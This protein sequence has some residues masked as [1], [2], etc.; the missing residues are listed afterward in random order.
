MNCKPTM[1]TS[2]KNFNDARKMIEFFNFWEM[3][4]NKKKFFRCLIIRMDGNAS[5]HCAKAKLMFNHPN[6]RDGFVL[7]QWF[8]SSKQLRIVVCIIAI[9]FFLIQALMAS[10]LITANAV[11]LL[12]TLTDSD[13]SATLMSKYLHT[14]FFLFVPSHSSSEVNRQP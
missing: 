9:R 1:T 13:A 6:R 12:C 7:K 14:H 11:D 2:R 10:S 8:S 3:I 4:V 5:L